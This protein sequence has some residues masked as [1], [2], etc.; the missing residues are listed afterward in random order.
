MTILVI[1]I[2]SSCM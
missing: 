1:M 2:N